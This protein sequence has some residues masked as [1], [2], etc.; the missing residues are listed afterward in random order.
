MDTADREAMRASHAHVWGR[1]E[2]ETDGTG[3]WPLLI[4]LE[5]VLFTCFVA[6][7]AMSTRDAPP[8][9][10]GEPSLVADPVEP[11]AVASPVPDGVVALTALG[12]DL[13]EAFGLP[14]VHVVDGADELRVRLP[15]DRLFVD[16]DD[17]GPAL[18]PL[19]DRIAATAS[20]LPNDLRLEISLTL[21]VSAAPWPDDGD[22]L[23]ARQRAVGFARV[24]SPVLS[25]AAG[26]AVGIAPG[27]PGTAVMAFRVTP[28]R[29]ALHSPGGVAK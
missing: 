28:P 8:P 15:A 23:A 17:P 22:S 5:L 24:A 2:R 29:G 10:A 13:A 14:P 6:L 18:G 16:G 7:V 1:T 27:Q 4:G 12:K 19:L 11:P 9:P 20:D 25:P 3:I 26:V 21:S